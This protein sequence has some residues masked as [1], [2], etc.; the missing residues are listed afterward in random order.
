MNPKLKVA[1]VSAHPPGRGTLN[2]YGFYLLKHLQ[3]NDNISEVTLLTDELPD[4]LSY[5]I[6]NTGCPVTVKKSWKFNSWLNTWRLLKEVQS[7][8]PDVVLFNIQ[9][10]SFGDK[11]IPAALGLLAPFFVKMLGFKSVV[12]LHNIME[13][14]DLKGAGITSNRLLASIYRF[15]GSTLTRF[16]LKAD[17]VAVTIPK[18]VE[19]LERKYKTGNVA[20]IPHGSFEVPPQPNLALPAGPKKVMTFGKFGTYKKVEVVIDAVELVRKKSDMPLEIVIAGTDSPNR[21]GYLNEVKR[22]YAHVNN[23][24]FTGYVEEEDVPKIFND[25]AV[26]V[27]P[28]TSTTGSSGVLHQAGSYGKAV[29]MPDL[30][31]LGELMRE[32]GYAGELFETEN[33]ESLAVAIQRVVE[34]DAYRCELGEK[35]YYAAVSLPM[36]DIIDW[37]YL[38]FLRILNK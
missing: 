14:V 32:E 35:N 3:Q 21:K 34:D 20:L 36:G 37:Y 11:K 12:L 9:F 25:S 29:I 17:M 31:D 19:T 8:K 28:Y 1:L 13:E 4:G 5:D 7:A 23:L 38:H 24:H 2:E 26:V 15:V 18:F 16:V 27:F 33:A 6:K 22:Q 10:L 30:G